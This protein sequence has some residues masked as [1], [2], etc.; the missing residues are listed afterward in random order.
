MTIAASWRG[1]MPGDR[2]CIR[3]RGRDYRPMA[4]DY[5]RGRIVRTGAR[6]WR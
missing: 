4:G 1:E 6:R 5:G 3:D 2:D